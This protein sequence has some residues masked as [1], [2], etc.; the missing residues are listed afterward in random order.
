MT[1]IGTNPSFEIMQKIFSEVA[2]TAGISN[3]TGGLS[4][5]LIVRSG[6]NGEG[7]TIR[8]V[9]NYSSTNQNFN[10]PFSG[11]KELLSGNRIAKNGNTSIAPWDLL[12][13]EE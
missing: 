12:I 2:Q 1:Y 3:Q 6:K 9:F 8:Y 4:F 11:G 10:Y 7:K 13:V 5:P